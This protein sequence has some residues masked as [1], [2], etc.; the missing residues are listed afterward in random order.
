[1]EPRST[2][3]HRHCVRSCDGKQ[4]FLDY[5]LG[6]FEE[7]PAK[8]GVKKAI[9][10]GRLL[11]NGQKVESGRWLKAGDEI[12]LISGLG[13]PPKVYERKISILFEDNHMAVIYK[14]AGMVA[15]G[16]QFKTV[17]NC[18]PFN[19]KESTEKSKLERPVPV[20]RLDAPTEGLLLIAKTINA[21]ME[22][23][24][25][26]EKRKILKEYSAI[27]Q[28]KIERNFIMDSEIK[29]Q[30]AFTRSEMVLTI[31]SLKNE[32]L[33][34]LKLFPKTGRTHQIRIHLSQSGHPIVGDKLYGK[35]GNILRNKGLF[36]AAV[37]L[38]FEHPVLKKKMNFSISL[39]HKFQS[40]LEREERRWKKFNPSSPITFFKN[41]RY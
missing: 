34:L 32:H 26:F 18:L 33:S 7:L 15:S 27:V 10:K 40:L 5:C 24:R 41:G 38:T 19:L 4:R 13:K 39:P 29:G 1:M 11:L 8:A 21:R 28:G 20:H 36:L 14:P 17:A 37:G 30:T 22:L 35:K 2:L 25:Q 9:A 3:L 6:L 12:T 23:Y 31:P 16:N